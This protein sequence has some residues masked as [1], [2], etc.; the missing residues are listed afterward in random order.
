MAQRIFTCI[1][2]DGHKITSDRQIPEC[3]DRSQNELSP[4]GAL[5]RVLGPTLTAH[6]I[7]ALEESQQLATQAQRQE[8]EVKR[9]NRALLIR[10][11]SQPIHDNERGLALVPIETGIKTAFKKLQDI[12]EQRKL[13]ALEMEFYKNDP[14][15]APALLK[16]KLDDND[17]SAAIQK[18]FI[19][20]LNMQKQRINLR[21][22]EELD[23]LKLLWLL[24]GK[25]MVP[26][27]PHFLD[28]SY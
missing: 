14:M 11:A 18:S 21:F 10:Y 8:A 13:M 22:D 19:S 26:R 2:A 1:N 3:S 20:N 6:E 12:A 9:R 5:K 7:K 27:S 15:K 4:S 16:Q 25:E 28:K 24:Q 23:K 17:Q